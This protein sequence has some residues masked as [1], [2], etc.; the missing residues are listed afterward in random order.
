[1]SISQIEDD[2]DDN[3]DNYKDNKIC[4]STCNI[5]LS[6]FYRHQQEQKKKTL[7]NSRDVASQTTDDI[8]TKTDVSREETK[9]DL[10][11]QRK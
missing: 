3:N 2:E 8:I 9:V 6:N 1:M 4:I 10:N 11:Q 5:I 7:E